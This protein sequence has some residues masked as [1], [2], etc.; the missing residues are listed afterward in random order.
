MI[1]KILGGIVA[2]IAILIVLGFVLPDKVHVERETVIAAPQEEVFA[3]ISDFGAW[4]AW[5]PWAKIDPD[6]KYTLTGAGVG[7][8]MAWQ[9][10]HPKVGNGSQE[11]T[12]LEAPSRLV[13]QLEFDGMGVA[14]ATFKLSPAADGATKVVWSL[15]TAMREGMAIHM[16]PMATYMGFFMDDMVGK[17]YARGL[18]NLKK[19]AEGS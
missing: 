8:K 6:A 5:S 11:I 15:D 7:Q 10:D 1:G 18:E 14:E 2:L 3:L 9:S 13:T 4:D 19:V 12:E 17:D 16:Q